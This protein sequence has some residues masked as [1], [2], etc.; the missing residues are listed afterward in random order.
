MWIN[1]LVYKEFVLHDLKDLWNASMSLYMCVCSCVCACVIFKFLFISPFFVYLCLRIYVSVHIFNDLYI[2]A[3]IHIFH[4]P[5]HISVFLDMYKVK[6]ICRS[7]HLSMC[8]S[9]HPFIL[10]NIVH[11]QYKTEMTFHSFWQ[12]FKCH[13]SAAEEVKGSFIMGII[14]SLRLYRS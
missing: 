5:N 4:P 14:R 3:S 6:F 11:L 1:N 10:S 12:C 13:I 8:F 7:I 9:I 2:C